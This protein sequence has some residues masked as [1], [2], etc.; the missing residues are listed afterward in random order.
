MGLRAG[1]SGWIFLLQQTKRRLYHTNQTV[2]SNTQLSVTYKLESADLRAF[3]RYALKNLPSARRVRYMT[4]AVMAALCLWLTLTSDDHRLGFRIA[5]FFILALVFWG[6]MSLWLF[7]A[8]RISQGRAYTS[9]KH[10]SVLCEHT[11]TLADDAFIDVT[12]CNEARNLWQGIYQV[13]DAEDHVYIF[14]SVHSAH[15][16]PKRAFANEAGVRKFYERA[17]NLQSAAQRVAA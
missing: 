6:L 3:Q 14:T 5:Y 15:I 2:N 10:R 9:E 17:F 1:Q 12:P 11:A 13:A 8:T 7:I 4:A 16:I